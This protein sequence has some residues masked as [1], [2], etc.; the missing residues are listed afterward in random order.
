[1]AILGWKRKGKKSKELSSAYTLQRDA[2]I[3]A[4]TSLLL[5]YLK[6]QEEMVVA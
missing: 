3:N 2:L 6:G 1:M 4:L 5:L